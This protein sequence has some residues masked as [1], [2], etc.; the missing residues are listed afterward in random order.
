MNDSLSLPHTTRT[1]LGGI[2]LASA[3]H[4]IR[5]RFVTGGAKK[6]RPGLTLWVGPRDAEP[7]ATDEVPVSGSGQYQLTVPVGDSEIV[8]VIKFRGRRLLVT[9][10]DLTDE[11]GG[12]VARFMVSKVSDRAAKVI[13]HERSEAAQAAPVEP[14]AQPTQAGQ[15][16]PAAEP[17]PD[18]DLSPVHRHCI[19]LGLA[20]LTGRVMRSRAEAEAVAIQVF[21]RVNS[22]EDLA[23][24]LMRM[25]AE[26]A[27]R[28]G[29][30][31]N[32]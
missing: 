8:P 27:E 17:K 32:Q 6:G 14:A 22:K 2:V 18:P 25:F 11:A 28:I 15:P 16:E 20:E 4:C 5:W 12:P 31:Y 1:P 19:R 24:V 26:A 7:S 23:A 30:G 3:G 29:P 13:E 9:A 10:L 21:V